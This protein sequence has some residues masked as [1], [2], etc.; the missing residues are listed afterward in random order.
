MFKVGAKVRVDTG[1]KQTRRGLVALVEKDAN[2][3]NLYDIIFEVSPCLE[4][5][6]QEVEEEEEETGVQ[7]E[8]LSNVKNFEVEI[9]E[10]AIL[11][12]DQLVKQAKVLQVLYDYR[13]S[14][15]LYW[16]AIQSCNVCGGHLSVGC[17][18]LLS[19]RHLKKPSPGFLL[20]LSL[21]PSYRQVNC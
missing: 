3:N 1:K 7:E 21:S 16:T 10:S 17:S 5:V 4:G 6:S 15:A 2:G 12:A 14:R 20:F 19:T 11:N 13:S 8:R 9:L 18:V